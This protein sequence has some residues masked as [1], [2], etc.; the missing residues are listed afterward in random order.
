MHQAN[1]LKHGVAMPSP[2]KKELIL[3]GILLAGF[4]TFFASGAHEV[5][6]WQV[7]DQHYTVIKIFVID[8][9]QVTDSGKHEDL[10]ISSKIYKNFYEKQ[11]KKS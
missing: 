6:S 1:G 8:K 9:G 4:I 10:L 3:P 5:F 11:I 7:L 2:R